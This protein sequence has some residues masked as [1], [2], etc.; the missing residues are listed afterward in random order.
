MRNLPVYKFRPELIHLHIYLYQLI[1]DDF[2]LCDNIREYLIESYGGDNPDVISKLTV[3]DLETIL[4]SEYFP[5]NLIIFKDENG[6]PPALIT[7]LSSDQTLGVLISDFQANNIQLP[8]LYT[9]INQVSF[10]NDGL[11]VMIN[12]NTQIYRC[13]RPSGVDLFGPCHDCDLGYNGL[14]LYRSS[15]EIFWNLCRYNGHELDHI[16]IMGPFESPDVFPY[17]S[18]RDVIPEMLDDYESILDYYPEVAYKNVEDIHHLLINVPGSF[19]VLNHEYSGNKELAMSA[20]K[21]N[22]LAFTFLNQA[23]RNDFIFLKQLFSTFPES[24]EIYKY[25]DEDIRKNKDIVEYVYREYPNSLKHIAPIEDGEIIIT[26]FNDK[27][28]EAGKYLSLASDSL[29]NDNEFLLKLAKINWRLLLKFSPALYTS[30]QFV[31]KLIKVVSDDLDKNKQKSTASE[32]STSID[33]ATPKIRST[34]LGRGIRNPLNSLPSYDSF[35]QEVYGYILQLP[36]GIILF[37]QNEQLLNKFSFDLLINSVPDKHL[38]KILRLLSSENWDGM[39]WQQAINLRD[40][41]LKYLPAK[42][43]H[44]TRIDTPRNAQNDDLPF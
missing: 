28:Y 41:I 27:I 22:V 10:E 32:L 37:Q 23:L 21:S 12:Y 15:S 19:R 5:D 6:F 40:T 34:L 18:R 16:A 2:G 42:Y 38:S 4:T 44:L 13:C 26:L 24:H 43:A 29:Q 25:L 31:E 7:Q 33:G 1:E 30:M 14:I 39:K 36:D 20:V 35:E 9:G 3:E 17:L 11:L 8:R